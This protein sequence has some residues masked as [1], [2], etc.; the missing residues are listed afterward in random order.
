[1]TSGDPQAKGCE[2]FLH[3]SAPVIAIKFIPT[4]YPNHKEQ[5]I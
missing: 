4:I 3:P 1:M 2:R 5:E